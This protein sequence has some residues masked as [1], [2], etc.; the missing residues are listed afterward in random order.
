LSRK[1][2]A[3]PWSN[4]KDDASKWAIGKL[5][6]RQT[7]IWSYTFNGSLPACLFAFDWDN[8][9]FACSRSMGISNLSLLHS[10]EYHHPDSLQLTNGKM[11]SNNTS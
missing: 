3:S 6:Q 8:V 1:N 4:R 7:W 9:G 5:M 10:H 11:E 2:N